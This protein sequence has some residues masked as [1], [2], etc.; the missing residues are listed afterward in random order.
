MNPLLKISVGLNMLLANTELETLM[1]DKEREN[2]FNMAVM[3]NLAVSSLD[4]ISAFKG[5]GGAHCSSPSG[6]SRTYTVIKNYFHIT[7]QYH[8]DT[9]G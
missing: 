5:K 6:N 3:C 4:E 7:K 2:L 8:Y 9:R 1:D